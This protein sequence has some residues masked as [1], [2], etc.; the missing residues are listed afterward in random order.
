MEKFLAV[1]FDFEKFRPYLIGSHAFVHTD[2]AALKH[3]FS[4]KDAKLRLLRWV[5]LLQEF[6]CEIRD[7]KGYENLVFDRPSRIILQKESESSI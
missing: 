1:V 4:K 6:G 7:R 3:I 2:L 5:L